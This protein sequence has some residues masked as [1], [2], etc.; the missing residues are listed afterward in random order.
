LEVCVIRFRSTPHHAPGRQ[1]KRRVVALAASVGLLALTFALPTPIAAAG[2]VH[3][4]SPSGSDSASGTG[5]H[6]WRTIYASLR[7]LHPGDTLYVRGGTYSFSGVNYTTLAGTPTR[8]ILISNYPGETPTFVG[9]SAPADFLYFS[10]N[11]SWI[12]VRGLTIRGGG[13]VDD[14]NGSSLLGFI[15][16]A[17][18]ITITGVRLYGESNWA[19]N[20]HLAYLAANAVNDITITHS[21]LDGRGCACQGLLQ[22]FHDPSAADVTV[23]SNVIRNSDQG[24]MVW[25]GV[26][27]LQIVSNTFSHV[28]I[29]IRHHNSMGTAVVGNRGTSVS[30]GVYADSRAHLT[31]SGNSW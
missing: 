30:I 13:R 28:R 7:K 15:G 16:N 9:T 6:P 23:S 14:S 18:H 31:Q 27:S 8:R 20:Q 17:N 25:A 3:Y 21:L 10:G 4:M 12:T 22:F 29:A 11:A 5:S 2:T 19:G 1:P 26:S 24:I